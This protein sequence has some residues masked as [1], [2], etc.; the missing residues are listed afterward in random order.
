MYNDLFAVNSLRN[1]RAT[2]LNRRNRSAGPLR[3]RRAQ[4][5]AR[6]HPHGCYL[7]RFPFVGLCFFV[8]AMQIEVNEL[9][10]SIKEKVTEKV[11]YN[12]ITDGF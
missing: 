6:Y 11:I 8:E 4:F 7:R 2:L 9:R 5:L 3:F 1:S 12:F 10:A